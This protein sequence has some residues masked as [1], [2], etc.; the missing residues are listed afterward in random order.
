MKILIATD[1]S[2]CSRKAI[3]YGVTLAARAGAEVAGIYVINLKSLEF[4]AMGHHDNI[5][6][7]EN[8]NAKL[9]REG[10][11]ALACLKE[12]CEKAGVKLSTAIVRGYP[13]EEIIRMAE[14][15]KV[16]MI[17][18]GNVGRTGLEHAL[19]GSISE[20][21]VRKAPCPVLVVRGN[22]EI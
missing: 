18:V 15:E 8:E 4:F 6:G 7:Y 16:N 21:V 14:K 9:H 20:S 3:N 13:T 11:E 12:Q 19:M 2:P 5:S 17:V 1:G 22:A 10:E